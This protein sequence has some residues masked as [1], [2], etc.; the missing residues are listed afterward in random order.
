MNFPDVKNVLILKW[1]AL[2]DLI[3]STSTI[4]NIR[5]NFP[6]AN[7]TM[8]TNHLMKEILPEGFLVDEYLF[9]KKS[10]RHVDEPFFHQLHLI[11]EIR[12]RKFDIAIDL[13]W[14]SERASVL[15]WLS[16]ADIRVGYWEKYL[17]KF[18]T[19]TIK[20]PV[21]GYHELNRNLDVIKAI[22]LKI[23]VENP[24]IFISED[25]KKFAGD[26]LEAN[27]LK[28]ENLICIHPGA[29]K[30]NR[31]WAIERFVEIAKRLAEKHGVK[32]LVTWGAS[33][34]QLAQKLVDELNGNAILSPPTK[35]ISRL[36]SVIQNCG[37]FISVCTGPMNVANA[38]QT[39]IVALL[40]STDPL[41]WSPFGDINRII[42]SPLVLEC[43]TDEDEK[44]ALEQIS[45]ESV[46]NVVDKR[47]EE[48]ILS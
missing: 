21:G 23:N 10:G 43:Y 20:H 28:K 27:S 39:P 7:I 22:Q 29:S 33:E 6:G 37:M 2:G 4:K 44:K 14:K 11:R 16:G 3:M 38:V 36:G 17:N 25:D 41:D 18:Y 24:V 5:E 40:G 47:W 1:G 31:A 32:I 26:F 42:K 8:L 12:K 35:S 48:L 34:L 15:T 45:V 9:I 19:H 46:W 30:P 13:K